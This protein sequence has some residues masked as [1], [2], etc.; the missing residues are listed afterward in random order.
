MEIL[1]LSPKDEIIMMLGNGST[2]GLMGSYDKWLI[3]EKQ[4]DILRDHIC[5]GIWDCA[6]EFALK[7]NL[8][9]LFTG[10]L[11]LDELYAKI[12]GVDI[13]GEN[14]EERNRIFA[15]DLNYCM[16]HYSL[17]LIPDAMNRVKDYSSQLNDFNYSNIFFYGSKPKVMDF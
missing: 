3:S 8:N 15:A 10:A 9:G 1:S 17:D 14:I 12:R 4:V 7:H 16:R 2:K 13:R 6:N 5:I 11:V